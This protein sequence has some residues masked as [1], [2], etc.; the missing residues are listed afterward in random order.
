MRPTRQGTEG[1]KGADEDADTALATRLAA[2]GGLGSCRAAAHPGDDDA[3]PQT[4]RTAG[5]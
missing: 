3:D 1:G 5:E 2:F 4:P